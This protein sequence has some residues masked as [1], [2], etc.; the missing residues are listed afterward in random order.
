MNA[1]RL[2]DAL[3]TVRLD[4][5]FNPYADRCSLNDE[6]S[7]PVIRKHNLISY[8]NAAAHMGAREVWLGRDLGYRGGRRT[9]L[10]LTD[11]AHLDILI[12]TYTGA[13]VRKA[14]R[15]AAVAE[16]TAVEIWKVISVLRQPPLLWNVF[17][18]HPHEPGRQMTNRR[19]AAA[20]L[21]SI[22][23]IN[24]ELF[25]WLRPWRILALGQ[26]A[27]AYARKLGYETIPIRHPSYGG[28]RD[29]RLAMARAYVGA[30]CEMG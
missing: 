15:G 30:F 19:F 16:R 27:A 4:S 11:E 22:D 12:T 18:L 21:R 3:S 13:R 25:R 29:F 26:D 7:A 2:V 20:E 23:D 5:V 17:P 28:L 24:R 6:D 9:G 10:P 1:T 14:T 8:L